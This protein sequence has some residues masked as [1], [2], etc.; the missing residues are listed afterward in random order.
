M[1]RPGAVSD[2]NREASVAEGYEL[3]RQSLAAQKAA[4]AL[5]LSSSHIS[6]E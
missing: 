5:T 3:I 1:S 6:A 4:S 2:L